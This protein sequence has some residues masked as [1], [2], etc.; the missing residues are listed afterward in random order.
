MNPSF[1]LAAVLTS[2]VA[3]AA[4]AAPA[5]RNDDFSKLIAFFQGRW[6]CEGHF[7]D[8]KAIAADEAFEPQL[9]GKW[10][11]QIHHDRPPFSYHAYS[12][13]GMDKITHELVV[14]IHDSGGGLRLFT[15]NDWNPSS[16]TLN[17]SARPNHPNKPQR[18]TYALHPPGAFSFEYL[19]ESEGAWQMVDHV[20]CKR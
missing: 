4:P 3:V 1:L 12:M 13:W 14:T 7:A 20:D 5:D 10:L 6:T 15:S 18:F 11:Q 8:G 2:A 17:V 16:M 19:V 9:D